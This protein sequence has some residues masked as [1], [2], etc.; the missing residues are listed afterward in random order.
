MNDMSPTA[1]QIGE[2]LR[3]WRE[4]KGIARE[5]AAPLVGTTTRTLAR[6]EDGDTA[7]PADQFFWLVRLYDAQE[8]LDEL[9]TKWERAPRRG[10]GGARAGGE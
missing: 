3:A 1:S 10:A 5:R 7:P 2:A 9:L 6:W 4:R 8:D